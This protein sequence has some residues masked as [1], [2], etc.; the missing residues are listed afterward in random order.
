MTIEHH[1]ILPPIK[2]WVDEGIVQ[3]PFR[4]INIDEHHDY[5]RGQPPYDPNGK[6]IGCGNWGYRMPLEWYD[7][8]TWVYNNTECDY[9][10][11]YAK[12]WMKERGIRAYKRNQH[13][14]SQLVSKIV[15]AVFCVSPDYMTDDVLDITPKAIETVANHFRIDKVPSVICDNSH[16]ALVTS[17]HILP[18]L[19]LTK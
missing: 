19:A 2:Q 18:R 9:D 4:I 11:D 13:R 1:E 16:V 17:W 8:F 14:L 5:Y 15:A 10:W 6:A 12:D 3:T 7:T